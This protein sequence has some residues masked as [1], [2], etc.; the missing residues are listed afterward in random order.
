MSRTGKYCSIQEDSSRQDDLKKFEELLLGRHDYAFKQGVLVKGR[1]LSVDSSSATVD[2][3]AKTA[4]LLPGR[5]VSYEPGAGLSSLNVGEEHE[6]YVLREEDEDG[7]LMVSIKRVFQAQSWQKLEE[8]MGK[9]EA[10]ECTINSSVKGG[11]LVDVMGLR[12][13]IPSSHLRLRQPAE[14]MIG[15]KI[16]C[17]FLSLDKKRN[18]IIL[19]HRRVVSEQ[20]AEQRRDIFQNIQ[21][22]GVVEGQVVRL[23]DFGA[24]VDLGGV[25]GLLPLS[26]MSWRWVEH[27][28][29]ILSIGDNV[30][31]EVIGVDPER[32]RVS[33]SIKSQQDDP[34]I[35]VERSMHVNLELEGT[36][37]RIKHFGAFV[38]IYPGV[39]ALLP[40][41]EVADYEAIHGEKMEPQQ[42]ITTY[43]SKFNPEERR[44]SLSLATA[45]GGQAEQ[46]FTPPMGD[47]EEQPL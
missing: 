23:T 37:T 47:L 22:G 16:E 6:F 43:I 34:W 40:S 29:D 39:E 30:K 42:K 4:A 2:V 46:P 18:N 31:V 20:L 38:E 17:K 11:V 9:D 32:H 28:S 1:I 14:S 26:Q 35:E 5:E 45:G 24:F 15:T 7:Q 12:G 10:V 41:K 33:L 21:V 27:P 19:S 44:I 3:G 36:V 25:D 8:I 13:F